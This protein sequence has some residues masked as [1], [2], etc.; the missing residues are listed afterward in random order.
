MTYATRYKNTMATSQSQTYK[1][2]PGVPKLKLKIGV[3]IN[4][5]RYSFIYFISQKPSVY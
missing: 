2:Q 3:I 1:Q 4:R 5:N